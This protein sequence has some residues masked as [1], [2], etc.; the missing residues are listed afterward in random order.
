MKTHDGCPALYSMY[1]QA[2]ESRTS[3]VRGLPLLQ[4]QPKGISRPPS[5]QFQVPRALTFNSQLVRKNCSL[6]LKMFT[7]AACEA[8]N[9]TPSFMDTTFD[10]MNGSSPFV[11]ALY[12][13]NLTVEGRQK[14]LTR[15]L[16]LKHLETSQTWHKVVNTTTCRIAG[17]A[18]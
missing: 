9:F 3:I 13:D 15:H 7:I 11:N 2:S 10:A 8:D 16:R 4:P 14:A 6:L 1:A 12:P 5:T 17:M 18:M